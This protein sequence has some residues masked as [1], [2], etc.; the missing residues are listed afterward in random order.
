MQVGANRW[1][2]LL[3]GL[4]LGLLLLAPATAQ[5]GIPSVQDRYDAKAFAR[6]Y[7]ANEWGARTYCPGVTLRFIGQ[8][9][10]RGSLAYVAYAKPCTIVFNKSIRWGKVPG[11][12][13]AD[14]W[15]RFC[16]T[17]MHE[18]G[19]LPGI[20]MPHNRNPDSIMAA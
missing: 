14:D 20:G 6:Q 11:Y 12:G 3:L 8:W 9:R 19:H 10:M 15:W 13:W 1:K 16:V 7:W 2:R 18:Y 5:A 17:L 4:A